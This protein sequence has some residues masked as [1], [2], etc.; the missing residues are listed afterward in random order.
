MPDVVPMH[1]RINYA[2]HIKEMAMSNTQNWRE[3][4]AALVHDTRRIMEQAEADGRELSGEE[5]EQIDRT[6]D[7][8]DS[9]RKDIERSEAAEAEMRDIEAA[10][11][12]KSEMRLAEKPEQREAKPTGIGSPDYRNAF[13]SY[14][15]RGRMGLDRD[16]VRALEAGTN[17]EGGYLAPMVADGHASLQ[18]MI[19]ETVDDATT[20]MGL[21]TVVN[22]SGEITIPTEA[23]LG[24][25]AWTAEEAAYNDSDAAFGQI[26]LTPHKATTH[27]KISEELLADSVVDLESYLARNFGR[28]F[29]NLLGAGFTNGSGSAQ[30]TGVTDGSAAGVTAASPTVITFDELMSLYYSLKEPYRKAGTWMFNSTTAAEIRG[31]KDSDG[32]YHWQPSL[33][34]GE[35]DTL[36]GRPVA[37][38]DNCEDTAASSKSVL[39]GD[40]SYYWIAMRQGV[41]LRRLDELYA[42]NGYV[43][44]IASV[45]VDGELTLSESV[46][47]ITQAAS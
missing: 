24:A 32:R 47:R 46:K 22:V 42:A 37:I 2:N 14:I 11:D 10:T 16:E 7:Q 23:T 8:V 18:S 25:A 17:S 45:R 1:I 28:R 20:M 35:P 13:D 30:P 3:Q 27:L 6:M 38:D 43:G 36:L 44:L 33:Q 41:S 12:R 4:R 26:T 29:A 15:R 21:A 31:L 39:F 34:A 9:L 5:R 40:M 19:M